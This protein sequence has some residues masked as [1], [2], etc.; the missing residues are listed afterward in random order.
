V[1]AALQVTEF[2]DESTLG[3]LFGMMILVGKLK[4][5]G[6]FE[7]LCAATL[8]ASRGKMWL[9]SVLMMYITGASRNTTAAA[10]AAVAVGVPYNC[11]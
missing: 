11:C 4:D 8:K 7:V 10:A 9:L 3:L 1:Y 6:L 5:T 2:L